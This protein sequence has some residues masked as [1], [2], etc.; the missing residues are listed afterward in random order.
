MP[1]MRRVLMAGAIL[2]IAFAGVA[3]EYDYFFLAFEI[4]CGL[5]ERGDPMRCYPVNKWNP[6]Y[7]AQFPS[8]PF[9]I[10]AG[11]YLFEFDMDIPEGMPASPFPN[12]LQAEL[13][14]YDADGDM[15]FRQRF[16]KWKVNR[17]TG[18]VEEAVEVPILRMVPYGGRLCINAKTKGAELLHG[19]KAGL[20]FEPIEA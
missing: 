18:R 5:D 8:S 1:T 17:Q 12:K 9:E 10:L 14:G 13:V 2:T 6:I 19:W 11:A 16:R 7:C 20:L 4:E 3:C 15:V